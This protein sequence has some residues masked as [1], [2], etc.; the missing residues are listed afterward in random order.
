MPYLLYDD[1]SAGGHTTGRASTFNDSNGS[2]GKSI[3]SATIQVQWSSM[4][5][6]VSNQ[7]RIN[8]EVVGSLRRRSFCH[9]RNAVVTVW[10]PSAKRRLL[11]CV[12]VSSSALHNIYVDHQSYMTRGLYLPESRDEQIT[13]LWKACFDSLVA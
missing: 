4:S 13:T 12:L 2:C 9:R 6:H 8:H 10:I 5:F 7:W 1:A 11:A 3:L